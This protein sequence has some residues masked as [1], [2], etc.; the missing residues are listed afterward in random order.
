MSSGQPGRQAPEACTHNFNKHN[1][2]H[3]QDND[4][5]THHRLLDRGFSQLTTTTDTTQ[6]N[7]QLSTNTNSRTP[8]PPCSNLVK[9]SIASLAWLAWPSCCQRQ[10]K[11]RKKGSL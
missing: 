9:F 4:T 10:Q 3:H 6:H 2:H 11:V 7:H 1:Q 5:T 8:P